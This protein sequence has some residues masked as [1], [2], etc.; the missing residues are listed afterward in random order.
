[1]KHLNLR[2]LPDLCTESFEFAVKLQHGDEPSGSK[3]LDRHIKSL[4]SALDR[5]AK[6]LEI[7]VDNVKL[8]QYALAAL[9]D[10]IVLGTD[11]SIQEAWS[12]RPLQLDLFNDY[13]AGE[14][15]FHKL[16]DLR[17]T[18]DP[19]KLDVLEIY[20]TCLGLG[21]KGRYADPDRSENPKMLVAEIAREIKERRKQRG[22]E[23]SA[24]WIRDDV[25]E[26]RVR[27]LSVWVVV[28]ACAALVLL[29]ILLFD[30]RLGSEMRAF[31][32]AVE[33]NKSAFVGNGR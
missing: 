19:E 16:D 23:L 12:K 11:W 20:A 9:F 29:T 2:G 13:T 32:A 5:Q 14:G 21:F 3:L 10:E 1:M 25:V 33:S 28:V 22:D 26:Q 27:A 8:A 30:L 6:L 17:G 7:N 18:R 4:F 24:H 31:D 15:F